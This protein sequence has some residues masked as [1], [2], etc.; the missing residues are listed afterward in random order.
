MSDNR[1]SFLPARRGF[2][3]AGAS[4]LVLS[5]CGS[6]LE[7]SNAAMQIYVLAPQFPTGQGSSGLPWQLAITQP[8]T[9]SSLAT[10][11][12]ALVR[13]QAMDYFANAQW[14]DG[15][16]ALVQSLLIEA[17]EKSGTT[18]AVA[19]DSD[20]IRATYTLQSGLRAFEARYDHGDGPPTVAVEISVKL[21]TANHGEI[22]GAKEFRQETPASANSIPAVVSAF[23]QAVTAV[24]AQIVPW[25]DSTVAT[26]QREET[27]RTSGKR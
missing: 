17:F 22:V 4:L 12:I 10:A 3:T 1:N 27:T 21:V 16:P 6:L 7:P 15:A 26:M 19:K 2:L 24:L 5:G 18:G 9:S 8:A 20:G 14:T 23:D 25:V 11:R 13:G